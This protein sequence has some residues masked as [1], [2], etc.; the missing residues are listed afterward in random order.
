M[1][2]KKLIGIDIV[3]R[4]SISK[5]SILTFENESDPFRGCYTLT[6]KDQVPQ[7]VSMDHLGD[8]V[9]DEIDQN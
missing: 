4:H 5:I 9:Q 8:R 2:M 1:R 7:I 6:V 3:H